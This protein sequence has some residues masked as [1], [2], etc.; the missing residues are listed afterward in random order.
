M[1]LT[2]TFL[3][4]ITG[5]GVAQAQEKTLYWQ[6]Y[7][8]NLA[9]QSNSDILVE[10]TQQIVFTGGSFTFGFAAIPQDRVEQIADL[11]V[12]EIINGSEQPYTPNSSSD[13]GFTTSTSDS[14]D[15]EITWYF[16][17][18]R[19]SAH[20]YILRYRVVGGLRIYDG[21]DQVWWKAIPPDHNFPIEAARVT[22]TL[23]QTFP[24]DQ[25]VV[26]SYGSPASIAYG[27][28]GEVIFTAE[29]IPADKEVEVRVEF[30][31]GWSRVQPRTGR[32]ATTGGGSG[33]R[34]SGCSLG[35][36]GRPSDWAGRR[37]FICS[38]TSAGATCP[39]A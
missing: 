18:T 22:V 34:S 27:D 14:G 28:R 15:L 11:Q 36:W 19:D 39:P 10:E 23:P 7:D 9:V 24:K 20:T 33:D 25:L 30:P 16:P 37:R 17:S 6:R 12:S 38:G 8:V 3:L 32:P 29:N 1:G 4:L 13:Y 5:L 35:P 26:A 21:G 2:L 31:Q